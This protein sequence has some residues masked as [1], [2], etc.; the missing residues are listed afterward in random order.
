L[1]GSIASCVRR[2][3]EYLFYIPIDWGVRTTGV[4]G[5]LHL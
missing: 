2:L 4:F 5:L 1:G 3:I